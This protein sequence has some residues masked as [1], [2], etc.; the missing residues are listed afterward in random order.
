[1]LQRSPHPANSRRR[2]RIE[3]LDTLPLFFKLEGAPVA[4]IGGGEG[5]AWKAELL[6]ATGADV[7]WL[8]DVFGEAAQSLLRSPRIKG[9]LN[10][11]TGSW[12]HLDLSQFRFVVADLE[13]PE[14]SDFAAAAKGANTLY[15]II[16]K[17]EHCQFQFGAIVNRSPLVIGI[18]TN[19]SVPVL[20]QVLRQKI[21]NLIPAYL[22]SWLTCAAKCRPKV[23]AALPSAQSR[24]KFWRNFVKQGFENQSQPCDLIAGAHT[25]DVE[26]NGKPMEFWVDPLSKTPPPET[27]V[28]AM[29]LAEKIECFGDF[30]QV[31]TSYLRRETEI[32]YDLQPLTKQ[33]QMTKIIIYTESSI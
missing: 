2:A 18:N 29:A 17:T 22:H 6:E 15:N 21:E 32:R 1:M 23:L 3:A 30:P 16:D 19:G 26:A 7:T 12:R 14:A 13:E 25:Y 27:L 31:L 24:R 11:Q 28:S 33:D 10:P 4:V 5:A 20:A 9:R 8:A